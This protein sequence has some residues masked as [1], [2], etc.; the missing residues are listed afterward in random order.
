MAFARR[1]EQQRRAGSAG[2]TGAADAMHVGLGVVRDVVVQHVR[3]AL[4]V[5]PAGGDVGGDEDVELSVLEGG[6]GALAHRLRDVAV[7]GHRRK[8][9]G[10]QLFGDLFGGL[11]G[12][13]EHDHRLERLDLEQSGQ[14]I[15]LAWAGHLDVALRDVLGGLRF[16]T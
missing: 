7:D 13:D 3:D 11:L 1:D 5:E 9:S 15:H 4:D 6:D 10:A 12:A 8:P 14:R 16:S 2:T